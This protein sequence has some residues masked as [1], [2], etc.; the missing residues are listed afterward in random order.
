MDRTDH[1]KLERTD[2]AHESVSLGVTEQLGLQNNHELRDLGPLTMVALSFDIC[3]SW[4]AIASTLAVAVNAGGP[5]TLLYG[6]ILAFVVYAAV[7]A[8]LAELASIYPTAGK[9][10]KWPARMNIATSSTAAQ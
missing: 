8:S 7:A 2:T 5:V 6:I 10:E 4:A 3:N 9:L 1:K